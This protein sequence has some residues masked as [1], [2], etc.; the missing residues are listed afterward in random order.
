MPPANEINEMEDQVNDAI[1]RTFE[2]SP[3]TVFGVLAGLLLLGLIYALLILRN[4]DRL[5]QSILKDSTK[6]L[7][8]GNVFTATLINEIKE[9]KNELSKEIRDT[10]NQ[11]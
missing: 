10:G 11:K 7:S 9:L 2:I 8:E 6:A 5:I 1:Q 3:D 4:R